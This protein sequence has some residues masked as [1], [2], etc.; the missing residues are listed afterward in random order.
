L[1]GKLKT[2]LKVCMLGV[3]LLMILFGIYRREYLVQAIP[4]YMQ[5][6]KQRSKWEK[7]N[8]GTYAYIY[9]GMRYKFYGFVSD[10]KLNKVYIVCNGADLK[11]MINKE[12]FK[13]YFTF[14]GQ[15]KINDFIIDGRFD[16]IASLLW[17]KLW[18]KTPFQ[19]GS[20]SHDYS[21]TIIYNEQYGYPMLI[22]YIYSGKAKS[23]GGD[24][25]SIA[26]LR[27][28]MFPEDTIYTNVLLKKILNKYH[29][30]CRTDI[31]PKVDMIEEVGGNIVKSK[32]TQMKGENE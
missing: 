12:N 5:Y 29:L 16:E 14:L 21:V 8:T 17:E 31:F 20:K 25:G 15:R 7:V 23:V 6:L 26:S 4:V 11:Y 10:N 28:M 9:L 13:R 22:S 32:L 30:Y 18:D 2:L 1:L 3:A 27:L 24:D 19:Y